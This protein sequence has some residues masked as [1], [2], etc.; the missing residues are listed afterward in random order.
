M[1]NPDP[2][3]SQ[4]PITP[5]HPNPPGPLKKAGPPPSSPAG[6]T[7]DPDGCPPCR[8][9]LDSKHPHHKPSGDYHFAPDED[10]P[11]GVAL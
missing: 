2:P 3:V 4:P 8:D 5:G 11:K 9:G 7:Q 6:T 10:D 1:P